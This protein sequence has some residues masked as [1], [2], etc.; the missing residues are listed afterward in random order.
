MKSFGNINISNSYIEKFINNYSVP[1]TK[2]VK[3]DKAEEE[4]NADR[5]EVVEV[6][7]MPTDNLPCPCPSTLVRLII[8]KELALTIRDWLHSQMD[9]LEE[10]RDKLL[11]LRAICEAGYLPRLLSLAEYCEEFGPIKK[12]TYYDWM[13]TSLN[14]TRGEID[15]IIENLPFR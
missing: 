13:G 7:P 3:K 6:K 1:D 11:F 10:A 2:D 4:D 15:G 8:R 14:Y 5:A 12:S 9:P